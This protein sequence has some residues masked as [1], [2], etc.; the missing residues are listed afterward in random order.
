MGRQRQEHKR[1]FAPTAAQQQR[2]CYFD[3]DFVDYEMMMLSPAFVATREPLFL[4]FGLETFLSYMSGLEKSQRAGQ[5]RRVS[6]LSSPKKG[7]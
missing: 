4:F 3:G 7:P 2:W 5:T 6:L 1:L